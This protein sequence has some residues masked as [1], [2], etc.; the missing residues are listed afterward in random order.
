MDGFPIFPEQASTMATRID[1]IYFVL[2]GLSVFFAVII[3]AAIL[4]FGIRYRRNNNVDRSNPLHE[5]MVIEFSWSFIP[6][7]LAMGIFG[8]SALIYLDINTPPADSLEIYVM[9]KQWMWQIQ[10]PSGKSES[11]SCMCPSTSR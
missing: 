10:H 2:L 11:T 7:L 5:S 1:T 8:W 4:F 6:F 3:A 9:G